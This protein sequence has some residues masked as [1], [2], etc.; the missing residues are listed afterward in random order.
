MKTFRRICFGLVL[1]AAFT[2]PV[3]A[4]E[5]QMPGA[6]NPGETQTP[7]APGDTQGPSAMAS[8]STQGPSA[9]AFGD[10]QCPGL[11]A[12]I[13]LLIVQGGI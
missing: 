10:T 2:M 13:I 11:T 6:P 4:G 5:V 7:P 8:G 9:M 3:L 12:S 1:L